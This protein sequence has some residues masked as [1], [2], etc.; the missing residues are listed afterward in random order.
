MITIEA[1]KC[2]HGIE[3]PEPCLQC[4]NLLQIE[5]GKKFLER[6]GMKRELDS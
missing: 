6:I 1:V 4:A 3:E 2:P 5:D